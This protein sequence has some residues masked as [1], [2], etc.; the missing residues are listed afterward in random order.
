ML[1]QN[2]DLNTGIFVS[3]TVETSLLFVSICALRNDKNLQ[4]TNNLR[5]PPGELSVSTLSCV[6]TDVLNI[7]VPEIPL[8]QNWPMIE[9]QFRMQVIIRRASYAIHILLLMGITEN[10]SVSEWVCDRNINLT[11]VSILTNIFHT[12]YSAQNVGQIN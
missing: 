4:A 9:W 10:I 5:Y 2:G 12:G 6:K 3:K 11:L 7:L 8:I 1:L